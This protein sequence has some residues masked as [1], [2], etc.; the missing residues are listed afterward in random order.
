MSNWIAGDVVDEGSTVAERLTREQ[1]R[2]RNRFKLLAAAEKVFAERGIQ[3]ASL[4]EVAAEAG[5]TKGAVYSNFS[6]KEELIQQVFWHR[7][8]TP[9]AVAFHK[10]MASR[11]SPEELVEAYGTL[12]AELARGGERESF[13]RLALEY[14]THALRHPEARERLLGFLSPAQECE[15]HPFAPAG[16]TMAA[17]PSQHVSTILMALDLGLSALGLIDSERFPPELYGVALKLLAGLEVEEDQVPP[18]GA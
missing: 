6:S 9:D 11:R 4:D 18:V 8:G 5:L 15:V 12:W 1:Q 2:E 13:S 7:Q 10:L 3:G 17:L 14:F 16:S